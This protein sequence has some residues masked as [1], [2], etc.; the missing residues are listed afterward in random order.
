[1]R[2]LIYEGGKRYED[3]LGSAV[4]NIRDLDVGDHVMF[5]PHTWSFKVT[6][7]N[8]PEELHDDRI[9][10]TIDIADPLSD[11]MPRAH[12]GDSGITV[13]MFETGMIRLETGYEVEHF[14]QVETPVGPW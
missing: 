7:I 3:L 13:H 5:G 8:D 14:R 6:D 2:H 9:I 1:M 4:W 11:R 10:G 12:P